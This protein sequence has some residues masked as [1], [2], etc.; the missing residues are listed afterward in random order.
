MQV[1]T[2]CQRNGKVNED[3]PEPEEAEK[4]NGYGGRIGRRRLSQAAAI[5]NQ[6]TEDHG[7]RLLHKLVMA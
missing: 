5:V 1:Q 4:E 7:Q 3:I 2:A 6:E